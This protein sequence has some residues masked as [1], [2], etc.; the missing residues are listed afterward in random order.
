MKKTNIFIAHHHNDQEWIEPLKTKLGKAFDV[1][2]SSIDESKPNDVTNSDYIKREYLKPGID[3]AGKLIVLVSKDTKDSNPECGVY[4]EVEYAN[5]K[6]Y[7]ITAVYVPGATEEDLM[8]SLRDYAD[9]FVKWDNSAGLVA[10][11]AGS[12]ISQGSD[13]GPRPTVLGGGIAC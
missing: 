11:L 10:A 6:G 12:I 4:W 2:D 13:G 8:P 5:K 3:W 1:R 7:P 9:N